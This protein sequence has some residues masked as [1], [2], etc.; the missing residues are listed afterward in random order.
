M[1]DLPYM[2]MNWARFFADAKV[3]VL[4]PEAQGI[5]A[6]LLGRMWLNEGW[7]S[8]D[9]RVLCRILGLDIR[10]WRSVYKP[11]IAPL[12]RR[13]IVPHVGEVY[14]QKHLQEVRRSSLAISE[15][16]VQRTAAARAAIAAKRGHKP[17]VTEPKQKPVTKPATE[18]VTE[19]ATAPATS[20]KEQP[21]QNKGS[22]LHVESPYSDAVPSTPAALPPRDQGEVEPSASAGSLGLGGR[23]PAMPSDEAEQGERSGLTK[24]LVADGLKPKR[25]LLGSLDMGKR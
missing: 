1:A 9:D 5:Y 6:L 20:S 23:F 12:L 10:R 2:M 15:K 22:T 19:T 11:A 25:G 17:T 21:Q 24:R 13:E 8:A 16:N 3:A 4:E 7:L 14:T 18:T